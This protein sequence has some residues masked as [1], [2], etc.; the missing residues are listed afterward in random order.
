MDNVAFLEPRD[1]STKSLCE[2]NVLHENLDSFF[3]PPYASWHRM[4]DF[5]S[6]V[7]RSPDCL[8]VMYLGSVRY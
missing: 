4:Q 2:Q 7:L 6:V 3:N 8:P 5:T 1:S